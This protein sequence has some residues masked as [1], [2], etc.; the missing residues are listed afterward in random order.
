MFGKA[1]SASVQSSLHA[2]LGDNPFFPHLALRRRS[3]EHPMV[4]FAT[5]AG[6]CLGTMALV[7]TAGPS[8]V[9]PD[10]SMVKPAEFV[11]NTG[12]GPRLQPQTDTDIACE[13]QSWGNEDENCILMIAR[14]SGRGDVKQ[15][16]MIASAEPDT[17]RPNIF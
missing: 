11:E 7:P 16:R 5:L 6:I 1:K 12:K 13:G 14:G 3:N 9:S 17:Q 15:I 10:R 4:M 2:E 8:L